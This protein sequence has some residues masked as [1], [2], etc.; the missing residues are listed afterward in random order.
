MTKAKAYGVA[1]FLDFSKPRDCRPLIFIY[2]LPNLT[3]NL[4]TYILVNYWEKENLDVF[5]KFMVSNFLLFTPINIR[6]I[7]TGSHPYEKKMSSIV[8]Y[9][10]FYEY[11]NVQS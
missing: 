4:F 11:K 2:F 10:V 5:I 6:W 3:T 8:L 1:D 7:R 9:L